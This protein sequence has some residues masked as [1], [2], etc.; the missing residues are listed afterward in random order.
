MQRLILSHLDLASLR[1]CKAIS[2]QYTPLARECIQR[3][4]WRRQRANFEELSMAMW[5]EGSFSSVELAGHEDAVCSLSFRGSRLA[6]GSRD[7]TARL[8]AVANTPSAPE[9]ALQHVLPHPNLVTCVALSEDG[10]LLSSG[11]YDQH[12]RLWSTA[13]G[14]CTRVLSG[15]TGTVWAAQW[16]GPLLLSGAGYP[17]CGVSLWDVENAKRIACQTE[18]TKAVRALAVGQGALQG[19]LVSGSYDLSVRLWDIATLRCVGT[20]LGHSREVRRGPAHRPS[21]RTCFAPHAPILARS[22]SAARPP[23][24][25]GPACPPPS[26]NAS[27]AHP[28]RVGLQRGG[29]RPP[30][31]ERQ[32]RPHH[33]PVGLSAR[34]V[35]LAAHAGHGRRREVEKRCSPA[36]AVAAQARL[37]SARGRGDDL[38]ACTPSA[39]RPRVVHP[40]PR[41]AP[42][43]RGQRRWLGA[44]LGHAPHARADGGR[45]RDGRWLSLGA[46]SGG[47]GRGRGRGPW[48]GG[49]HARPQGRQLCARARP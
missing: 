17:E 47:I 44:H 32:R 27:T 28:G 1:R 18:H 12:I 29:G 31:R 39:R 21:S 14:E 8:W 24:L 5:A 35:H 10:A 11:C 40:R 30:H 13:T 42:A 45:R 33:L 15:H 49:V 20:R 43:L 37:L 46:S 4:D 22:H 34:A 48:P 16:S 3:S 26:P 23:T 19:M 6:S 2:Q 9:A 41:R 7:C 38:S 25:P 36:V